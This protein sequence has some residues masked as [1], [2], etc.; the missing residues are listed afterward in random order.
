MKSNKKEY[1]LTTSTPEN[2]RLRRQHDLWLE[3]ARV[4]WRRARLT[5]QTQI[6][7]MGSGPGYSTLDLARYIGDACQIT[8]IELS[9]VYAKECAERLKEYPNVKVLNADLHELNLGKQ[10]F[11]AVFGRWIW[12]WLPKPERAL[13]KILAH[14][15][16]GGIIALQEY[17]DYGSMNLSS[18]SPIQT[19]VKDAI[20]KSFSDTGGDPDIVK[21][22]V[23]LFEK[24]GLEIEMLDSNSKLVRPQDPTWDWPTHFYQTYLPILQAKNYLT[25]AQVKQFQKVWQKAY[26]VPG[27][28]WIAP[29][30]ASVIARKK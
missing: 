23:P 13:Q 25:S 21:R 28:F 19:Q 18:D 5:R 11:D 24:Y 2:L 15:K 20:M 4:L 22:L 17:V 30:V 12:M 3:D 27:T 16:P 1:I 29:T 6:L 10:K 8:A 9:P 26:E 14:L 7:E